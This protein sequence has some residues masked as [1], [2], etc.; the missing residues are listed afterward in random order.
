[1]GTVDY[2]RGVRQISEAV[3]LLTNVNGPMGS[4]VEAP[5]D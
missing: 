1:M 3:Q 4:G 2:S 5:A